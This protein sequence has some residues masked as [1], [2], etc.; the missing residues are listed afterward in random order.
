MFRHSLHRLRPEPI[1]LTFPIL[2]RAI[3]HRATLPLLF[4][5]KVSSSRFFQPRKFATQP[6]PPQLLETREYHNI[7]DGSLE[8][9]YGAFEALMD[10]RDDIDVEFSVCPSLPPLPCSGM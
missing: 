6:A 5:T 3:A 1:R 7:A 9:L 8:I 10:D 2:T 4:S